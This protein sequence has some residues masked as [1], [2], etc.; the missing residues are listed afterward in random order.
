MYD[1]YSSVLSETDFQPHDCDCE[2][3]SGAELVELAA[4]ERRAR[5]T[6]LNRINAVPNALAQLIEKYAFSI[7]Q[8]LQ[9]L[10]AVISPSSSAWDRQ[11]PLQQVDSCRLLKRTDKDYPPRDARQQGNYP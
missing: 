4:T 1:R 7:D 3:E 5:H 9:P 6:D 8:Q 2:N 10:A 11:T